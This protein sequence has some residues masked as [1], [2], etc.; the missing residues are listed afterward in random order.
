MSWFDA[1][2]FR[3]RGLRRARLEHDFDDELQFHLD[4]LTAEHPSCEVS[5]GSPDCGDL[6]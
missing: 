3:L 2:R 4:Q 5:G 6:P 1:I